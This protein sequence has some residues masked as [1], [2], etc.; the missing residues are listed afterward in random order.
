MNKH[1]D[2]MITNV[3]RVRLSN[4]SS[5]ICTVAVK[6]GR[7]AA[8][9]PRGETVDFT[10]DKVIDGSGRF[11]IP[12]MIDLHV[13]LREPGFE[14]KEDIVSGSKCA[15]AGGVT[16]VF[17]MPN[18]KP[19]TDSTEVLEYISDKAKNADC[20]VFPVAAITK[21]LASEELCDM[22]A[23]KEAG[24]WAFSDDGKPVM[25]SKLLYEAMKNAAKDDLL[26]MSHCEDMSLAK[27]GAINEGKISR[28]LNIPGIPNL[29]EDVA[30]ERDIMV[31]EATGARLHICHVSTRGSL[32]CIRRAK[33]RGVKVTAETCP[34]YFS[35]TDADVIYYGANAKM[36]PPLRSEDD[37]KAV[38]EAICDGTI[39]CISTD[40]APHSTEEKSGDVKTAL[41]GI[42]GLQTSF[43]A[44]YTNLVMQG[45]I[46]LA[47]LIELMAV[48][49]A[50]ITGL[51]KLG[52]GTLE[53]GSPADF[54]IVTL[55][56]ENTVTKESLRGK[57]TNTPFVG[58]TFA[59]RVDATYLSGKCVFELN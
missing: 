13:H 57:S 29:A 36:N 39:D 41:N 51:D 43:A 6:D 40:H 23:L 30:T 50:R 17:A 12:G 24:A 48:N 27:G 21:G 28:M 56:C 1:F 59:A 32:D 34:H 42:I 20:R 26:I 4:G 25:T 14:Y 37:V 8:I 46:D 19:A 10:A 18:T 31:A 52:L 7:I 58:M 33:A 9:A 15:A 22:A 53:V 47:K 44:S 54:A 55:G 38:I 2:L 5:E 11:I 3:R 35:L 16:S 49:P 45:H